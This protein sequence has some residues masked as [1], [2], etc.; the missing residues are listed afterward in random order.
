VLLDSHTLIWSVE[1]PA[2]LGP[3]AATTLLDPGNELLVSAA[4]IW[5]IAIKIG[6]GKLTL[7]RPDRDWMN[8]ALT[9]L[10][11]PVLPIT[12]Q[13]A[14]IQAGLPNHHRDPF[15]RLII[16]QAQVDGLPIVSGDSAFDPYGVTRLW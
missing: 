3:V 12:V 7:P 15:D 9:D 13:Y 14:D 5:E 11:A 8:Q 1:Y 10:G 16:S 6:L 4:T 2:K